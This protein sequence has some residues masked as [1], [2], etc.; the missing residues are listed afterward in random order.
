ME[1]PSEENREQRQD[2]RGTDE[3]SQRAGSLLS[4]LRLLVGGGRRERREGSALTYFSPL[5]LNLHNRTVAAQQ[6][7]QSKAPC[8]LLNVCM[9]VK[10]K[11]QFPEG[12]EH[13]CVRIL[14][15]FCAI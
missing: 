11:M 15:F 9:P 14:Y 2:K 5:A 8:P 4:P 3:R 10:N 7:C 13:L 1:T 12:C 6:G